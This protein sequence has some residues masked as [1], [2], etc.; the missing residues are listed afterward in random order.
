MGL[1][2]NNNGELNE[3][4]S[5]II[6]LDSN[7]FVFLTFFFLIKTIYSKVS[8]RRERKERVA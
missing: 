8:T 6:C 5:L 3:A 2:L 4:F 1:P 7:K